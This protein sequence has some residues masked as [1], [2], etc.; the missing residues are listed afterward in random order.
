VRAEVS[1]G[2]LVVYGQFRTRRIGLGRIREAV[3]EPVRTASPFAKQFPYVALALE[4]VDG[5]HVQFQE[6]S[7]RQPGRRRM[8][9]FASA[10]N[11]R[12]ST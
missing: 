5:S 7:V 12:L 2:S 6:L 9:E 11:G 1:D 8:D 4:L 10:I 3:V